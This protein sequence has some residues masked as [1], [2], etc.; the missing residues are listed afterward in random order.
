MPRAESSGRFYIALAVA[1]GATLALEIVQT[2]LLSVVSWYHLAFFVISL[3][4]F[5]MTLGALYV[6][7]RP[8]RFDAARLDEHLSRS[9]YFAAIAAAVAWLDQLCLAPEMVLSASAV[10]VFARLAITVSV[11]FFFSGI[12]VTL[13]LTRSPFPIGRTY[14]A[15]LAGAALGCVAVIPLLGVLDGPSTIFVAASLFAVSSA[16]FAPAGKRRRGVVLAL[17]LVALAVVNSQTRFGLDPIMVKGQAEKRH[18]VAYERWNSFSRIIAYKPWNESPKMVMW[19]ASDKTPTTPVEFVMMNIDGLAGT[20]IFK[21][22]GDPANVDFLRYDVT[23]L[24]HHVRQGRAAIIGVGGGRDVMAALALGHREVLGVELNPAFTEALTGPYREFAGL[25]DHAGVRLVT[26][27]ARSYFTRDDGLY[28]VLQ[29]SLIDTWAATGAG[30][31]SLSENSIYTVEAWRVFL[32]RL[33]PGGIFT[34]SRWYAPD[35][36]DETARLLSLAAGTLLARGV[37]EPSKHILLAAHGQV[38]TILVSND[39]FAPRDIARFT[40]ACAEMGFEVV[41][42]PGQ[43]TTSEALAAILSKTN[44]DDLVTYGRSTPL[45]LTPP[46]DARPFFFNLLRLSRPWEIASYLGRPSGVVA[47]NLI[48]T[49]TL[50]VIFFVTAALAAATMIL[51]ARFA[52]AG[53]P[54]P[55]AR[56]LAYFALIGLAFMLSEIA[57][58]QQLSVYLGH[59]VYSLAVV[60]FSI[61]LFTGLGSFASDR[62]ALDTPTRIRTFALLVSGYLI[63][64][65]CALPRLTA[66]FGALEL[67]G[68]IGLCVAVLAPAGLLMGQ[69]FPAGMRWA[70]RGLAAGNDPTPWLWA[71]NGAAGVVASAAAVMISIA[72]GITTTMIAGAACYASIAFVVRS[73]P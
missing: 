72:F 5:G 6:F 2:R 54:R 70:R 43:E 24:A 26:D 30:A 28:D 12:V 57:F 52:P 37:A 38:A 7:L 59:P 55:G 61:I 71:V 16:L 41:L 67:A 51:P 46:T 15:D 64:M 23:T 33:T 68:R 14:G 42:A 58:L 13:A 20:A 1:T 73:D 60:L 10:V 36:L 44:Y 18:W 4:M 22:A 11:P 40:A 25:A 47:G 32:D 34:V 66:H 39:P 56:A 27:E 17:F 31:Y 9:A 65:A 53:S 62:F 48:A 69:A 21:M 35:R 29:A 49:L 50:I 3:A 19:A 8:E 63:A 45:D